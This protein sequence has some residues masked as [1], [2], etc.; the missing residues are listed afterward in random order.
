MI[1]N[2]VMVESQL[3]QLIEKAHSSDASGEQMYAQSYRYCELMLADPTLKVG[4]GNVPVN[5]FKF[6]EDPMINMSVGLKQKFDRGS[7]LDLQQKQTGTINRCVSNA[8]SST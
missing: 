6:D 7:S 3:T 1:S 4:F 2:Q 8:G 5:S